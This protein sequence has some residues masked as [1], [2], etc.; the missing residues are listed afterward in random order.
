MTHKTQFSEKEYQQIETMHGLGM[1]DAD[2]AI[3]MGVSEETYGRM[4]KTDATLR[5]RKAK[6]KA[7]SNLKV[8]NILHKQITREE[9]E[10]EKTI[11]KVDEDGNEISREVKITRHRQD[12]NARLLEFYLATRMGFVKTTK[13]EHSGNDGD[14]IRM[15]LAKMTDEELQAEAK[16]L[17]ID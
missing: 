9:I 13:L 6:G 12:P 11:I 14:P 5:E 3:I 4:L 7:V 15:R 2:I 8:L 1:N 16:K 17:D 10:K